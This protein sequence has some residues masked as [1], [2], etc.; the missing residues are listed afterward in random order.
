MGIFDKLLGRSTAPAPVIPPATSQSPV[1]VKYDK[2]QMKRV[3]GGY[4]L[5]G[6]NR[7]LFS[8]DLEALNP[9][10]DEARK[11]IRGMPGYKL[12]ARKL[13][14]TEKIDNGTRKNVLLK[15]TPLTSSGR[16][17]KYPIEIHFTVN[18]SEDFFGTIYY[19][20]SGVI[21][22]AEIVLWK[23][24]TSFDVN[25]KTVDGNLVVNQ[26]FKTNPK[27]FER[28]KVYQR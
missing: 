25:L 24:Y 21:E 28:V 5:L 4:L 10:L 9:L 27:T 23:S 20:Q 6:N 7:T 8:S 3:D 17:P 13:V 12:D 19:G 14:F 2:K 11:L 16:K 22:K 1:A 15:F 18:I 26:I